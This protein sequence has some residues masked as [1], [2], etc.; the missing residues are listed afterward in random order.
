MMIQA[1]EKD[2]DRLYGIIEECADWL[3]S[4]SVQQWNPV[5]PKKLF[6][7][8]VERGAVFYFTDGEEVIGTATLFE[9]KPFYYPEDVWNDKA[10]VWYLCRF[11]VPR[12]LKAKKVGEK[13]IEEIENKA[14]Q[15]GIE[16]IRMDVVK[17]NPFLESYYSK[18]GYERV[19]EVMLKD[20]PSILMQK[21]IE[22]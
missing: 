19:S 12:K 22:K 3:Q 18:F 11:A 9:E 17:A 6:F 7:K 20:T 1:T 14:K 15:R 2:I 10:K 21:R 4:K 13:I 5:Y 16:W 8:D